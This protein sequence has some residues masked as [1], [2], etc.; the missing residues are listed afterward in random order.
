VQKVLSYPT[1]ALSSS[2]NLSTDIGVAVSVGSPQSVCSV[3]SRSSLAT[4]WCGWG[5]RRYA[6]IRGT[7]NIAKY[8]ETIA[9]V[10]IEPPLPLSYAA[11]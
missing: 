2:L 11:N 5:A 8:L 6:A 3:I 4:N 1:W 9:N 7:F 10:R